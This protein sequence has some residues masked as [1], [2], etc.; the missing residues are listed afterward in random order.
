MTEKDTYFEDSIVQSLENTGNFWRKPMLVGCDWLRWSLVKV[1]VEIVL[2]VFM[3][4]FT[5][6]LDKMF[7]I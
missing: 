2:F 1:L 6:T 7:L 5:N 4:M 3:E